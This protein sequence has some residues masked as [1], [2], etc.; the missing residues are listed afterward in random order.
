MQLDKKYILQFLYKLH[1]LYKTFL[2]KKLGCDLYGTKK[3]YARNIYFR[4]ILT[5]FYIQI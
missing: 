2:N 1:Y 3:C 5:I 4:Q